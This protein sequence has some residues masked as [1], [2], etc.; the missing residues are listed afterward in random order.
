MAHGTPNG[1]GGPNDD[2]AASAATYSWVFPM[3]AATAE[4]TGNHACPRQ[5]CLRP[6]HR[7]PRP[8]NSMVARWA[9][10]KLR[11]IHPT[12]PCDWAIRLGHPTGPCDWA[13]RLGHPTG[14]SDWAIRLGHPTGPSDW[15][16]RLGHATGPCD[17]AI[18][19][20]PVETKLREFESYQWG[21]TMALRGSRPG[22]CAH[23]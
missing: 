18:R 21:A 3:P 11:R 8:L 20:G 16:I 14:P 13:I 7:T 6:R 2:G 15:A 23:V 12:G 9:P 10:S 1:N 5:Q 4:A 22:A 19:L 17:W